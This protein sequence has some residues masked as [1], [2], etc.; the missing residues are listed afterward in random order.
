MSM[1]KHNQDGAVNALLLS[2]II[3]I[4]AFIGALGFGFW[5]FAGMQDYKNNTDDKIAVA[6]A[7]AKR[8][9][10]ANKDKQYAEAAKNPLTTYNGPDQYGSLNV[11]YPKTWSAYVDA[12]GNGSYP[13]N[14]YFNPNV[15]PS[16]TDQDSTFALRVQVV[17]QAYSNV[18]R[19]YQSKQGI[20]VTPYALPKLPKQ[21]GV[22]IQGQIENDKKGTMVILPVRDKTL[23]IYTEADAFQNDFENIILPNFSFAP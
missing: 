15:V 5:A 14:G 9:E 17:N 20:T 8:V 1:I 6:V 3:A 2:L 21:V 18:V 16:V 10:A 12:S 13:L 23:Q 22:K 4:V 11:Q 19:N 7:E